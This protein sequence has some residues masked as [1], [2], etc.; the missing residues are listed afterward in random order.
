[1][2]S[3]NIFKILILFLIVTAS[4]TEG[5]KKYEEGPW[6]SF[7]SPV[8]RLYRGYTLEK[9]T[10]NGEDSLSLFYD[11]LGLTFQFF[12]N[13]VDYYDLCSLVDFRKDGGW[14]NLYWR[15]RL[16]DSDTKLEVYSANGST[17]GTGPFGIDKKPIWEILKFK[18]KKIWMKTTY[19]GKE[20][21]IELEGI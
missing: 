14:S 1:M 9:Y 4:L 16:I 18:N 21:Y 10:V 8:K 2:R 17:Y 6:I 15:W 3:K 13:D 5:C 20:Y 12:Y 7:R 19:N 11:S